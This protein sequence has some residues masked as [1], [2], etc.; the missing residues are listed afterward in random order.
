MVGSV[1]AVIF[2]EDTTSTALTS[3]PIVTVAPT[4]KPEPL[5]V[6]GVPPATGPEEGVMDATFGGDALM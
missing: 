1:V 6:T 3:L 4:R 5:I 2:V